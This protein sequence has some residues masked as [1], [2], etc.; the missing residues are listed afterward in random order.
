MLWIETLAISVDR[1]NRLDN[2]TAAKMVRVLNNSSSRRPIFSLFRNIGCC[3]V[4]KS[5]YSF[6]VGFRHIGVVC[7]E[8]IPGIFKQ[9]D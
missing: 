7:T 3:F 5:W 2:V 1:P 8:K 4:T 6:A 9:E